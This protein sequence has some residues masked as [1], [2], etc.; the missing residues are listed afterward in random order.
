[1]D[2]VSTTFL[3]C[4]VQITVSSDD[5][6]IL[7]TTLTEQYVELAY[8]YPQIKCVTAPPVQKR[9]CLLLAMH[10]PGIGCIYKHLCLVMTPRVNAL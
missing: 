7:R 4:A 9:L 3:V 8:K 5:P 1:M 10:K 2:D 6:G